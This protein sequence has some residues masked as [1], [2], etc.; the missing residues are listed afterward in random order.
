MNVKKFV[1]SILMSNLK[2]PHPKKKQKKNSK[3]AWNLLQV[4]LN[5]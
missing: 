5:I 1:N 2:P 3:K 4:Y